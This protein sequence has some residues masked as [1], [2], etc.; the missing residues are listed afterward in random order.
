MHSVSA[1]NSNLGKLSFAQ[2]TDGKW[3]YKVA[4]ADPV[5]PFSSYAGYTLPTIYLVSS[6][7][8]L[9]PLVSANSQVSI[10]L[11]EAK[12]ISLTYAVQN[13]NDMT[14]NLVDNN[15]NTTFAFGH[16]GRGGY[17]GSYTNN[18]LNKNYKWLS[19]LVST[20]GEAT[21]T[22]TVSNINVTT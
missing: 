21:N 3:G 15:G 16:S 9:N 6:Y 20:N 5:I 4:G 13:Y 12:G 1:I 17:S 7:T 10:P 22:A 18:S 11:T 8:S 19:I 14:A 2:S